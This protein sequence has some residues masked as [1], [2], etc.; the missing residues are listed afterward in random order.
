[1]SAFRTGL[2]S[3]GD[4]ALE[5][6]FTASRTFDP[7]AVGDFFGIFT[8]CALAES[9]EYHEVLSG[10]SERMLRPALY[11]RMEPIGDRSCPA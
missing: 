3:L 6:G 7:Q 4:Q 8:A 10:K 1:M 11:T 2:Q 9:I 5:H